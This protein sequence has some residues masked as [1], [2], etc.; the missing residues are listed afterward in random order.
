MYV[1]W[2]MKTNLVTISPDT[3]VLKAREIMDSK[4]ISHLPVT[5]GKARLLGIVTDRD[6]KEAWASPAS[7]L[8]VYELTYVLQKLKVEAIMTKK[9]LTASPDMTIERAVS[10]LHAHRIGALPVLQ[11]D[12]VVGIITSTDLMEVL[13]Q[14]LGMGEDSTRLTIIVRDRIGI[15]AEVGRAMQEAGINI[16]SVM[17]FPLR[18]FQDLWQLILRVNI[19]MQE[20]AVQVLTERGFKV[21]TKYVDDLT[22]YLP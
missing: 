11:N 18:D 8:S 21:I 22:P 1:G 20:K 5:D 12:K 4:K 16:R 2:H 17:T 13:L 3:P 6:L 15:L 9:V 19:A 10:I 7:T 14:A